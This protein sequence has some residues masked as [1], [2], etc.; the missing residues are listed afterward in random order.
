[1]ENRYALDEKDRTIKDLINL[2]YDSSLLASG[3]SLDEPATF[4]SRI[5]RLIKLGL[6]IDDDEDADD[7]VQIPPLETD[8]ADATEDGED[9]ETEMEQ[10][11]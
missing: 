9:G 1:M 2:M 7:D 5:N 6:S 3:F 8:G 4:T 10:V 11:D